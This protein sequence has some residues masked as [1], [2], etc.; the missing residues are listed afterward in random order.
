[1]AEGLVSAI[2]GYCWVEWEDAGV[3]NKEVIGWDMKGER[4][5]R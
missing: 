1:M 2:Q 3:D 5:G 4:E